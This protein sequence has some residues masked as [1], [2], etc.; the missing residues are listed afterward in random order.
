MSNDNQ[1]LDLQL[2][3]G[4]L[5]WTILLLFQL[6]NVSREDWKRLQ[7]ILV[8]FLNSLFNLSAYDAKNIQT[9]KTDGFFCLLLK[10][11]MSLY[12]AESMFPC[13]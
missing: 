4:I 1:C 3:I 11:K 12:N 10:A 13:L 6:L 8:S 5:G 2:F 9:V 7:N